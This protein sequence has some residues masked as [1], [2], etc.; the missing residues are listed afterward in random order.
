M[1]GLTT[2]HYCVTWVNTSEYFIY[3]DLYCCFPEVILCWT[4]PCFQRS[5]SPVLSSSNFLFTCNRPKAVFWFFFGFPN[6][7]VG[8]RKKKPSN[9]D[10]Y[11]CIF[12][13]IKWTKLTI[14]SHFNDKQTRASKQKTLSPVL[15][16]LNLF[17][18]L[19]HALKYL[20]MKWVH[21]VIGLRIR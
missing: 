19:L 5:P 7:H 20:N 3:P 18:L 14:V 13:P 17:F 21:V 9:N 2:P 11:V 8:S 1:P 6:S 10:G 15:G 4:A 12:P 16:Q